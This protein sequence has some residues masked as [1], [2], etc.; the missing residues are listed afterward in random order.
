M[1]VVDRVTVLLAGL[2]S[3][4]SMLTLA[5]SFNEP[6]A[7]GVTTIVTLL[8]APAARSP[9]VKVRT[10]PVGLAPP[11]AE[12]KA[13]PDGSVSVRVTPVADAVPLLV[14]VRV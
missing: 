11:V 12:T 4:W 13:A 2:G 7:A 9:R 6:A 3:V 14:T 5:T 1:T 8:S 10:P